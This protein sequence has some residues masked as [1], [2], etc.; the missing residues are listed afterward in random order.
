M[1]EYPALDVAQQQRLHEGRVVDAEDLQGLRKSS[2]LPAITLVRGSA[3]VGSSSV[4]SPRS[5]ASASGTSTARCS[6]RPRAARW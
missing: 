3:A 5:A 4:G 1:S 2:L 6:T